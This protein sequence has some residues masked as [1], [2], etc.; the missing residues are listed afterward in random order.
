VSGPRLRA[1]DPYP[2]RLAAA[3]ALLAKPP[4]AHVPV[5]LV[6]QL[7]AAAR[8]TRATLDHIGEE[9]RSR[10]RWGGSEVREASDDAHEQ[11]AAARVLA[12][13]IGEAHT[14][15]SHLRRG[16]PQIAL[17]RLPLHDLVCR[18]CSRTLRLP[19]PDEDDR[20]DWC[21]ARGVELF[22]P[23]TVSHGPILAIG[24][25]CDDC[26]TALGADQ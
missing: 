8:D 22:T 5:D 16:G 11:E 7:T 17:L 20:C 24:D 14:I 21:G 1:S 23:F 19:P 25:A 6:D 26:A 10:D 2:V 12:A 9:L 18:K 4:P 15:C 3:R 13:T